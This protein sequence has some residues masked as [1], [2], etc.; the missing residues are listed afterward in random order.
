[1]KCVSRSVWHGSL[2]P[3]ADTPE[4]TPPTRVQRTAEECGPSAAWGAITHLSASYRLRSTPINFASPPVTSESMPYLLL[5]IAA[6]A[7]DSFSEFVRAYVL[8]GPGP[9]DY[10]H[11]HGAPNAF[12]AMAR[13]RSTSLICSVINLPISVGS[14]GLRRLSGLPGAGLSWVPSCLTSESE[15]RETWTAESLRAVSKRRA[16]FGK[17][18][19]DETSA[20][21]RF[22]ST[23]LP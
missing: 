22:R 15:E 21:L 10:I 18:R 23:L 13:L 17:R 14:A 9:K 11:R 8:T 7:L 5:S 1:M 2:G 4:L 3:G 16:T 6:P 20:V 19:P 12:G